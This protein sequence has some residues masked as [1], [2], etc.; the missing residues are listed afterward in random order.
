MSLLER[1]AAVG[2]KISWRLIRSTQFHDPIFGLRR[3]ITNT[4]CL[5]LNLSTEPSH[6]IGVHE[7]PTENVF[8]VN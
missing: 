4:P 8:L 6:S 7:A 1:E 3:W 2:R 5:H